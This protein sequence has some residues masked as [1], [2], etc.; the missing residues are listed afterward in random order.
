MY[1]APQLGT[2]LV[3][4]AIILPDQ[5]NV[6]FLRAIMGEVLIFITY[7]PKPHLNEFADAYMKKRLGALHKNRATTDVV[8]TSRNRTTK[9]IY[10]Y[11]Q[12]SQPFH[13]FIVKYL[14]T[15]KPKDSPLSDQTKDIIKHAKM[16][17]EWAELRLHY[18]S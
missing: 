9:V 2:Y 6:V 12:V 3:F 4:D 10:E 13:A 1:R 17:L 11:W 14:I 16:V 15:Y 8:P 7:M 5:D 18:Y